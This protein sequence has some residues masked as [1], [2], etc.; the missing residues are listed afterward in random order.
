MRILV[1]MYYSR[2][3]YVGRISGRIFIVFHISPKASFM[4]S[5]FGA[6]QSRNFETGTL[7]AKFSQILE[8]FPKLGTIFLIVVA[9]AGPTALCTL[10]SVFAGYIG[11]SRHFSS[12]SSEWTRSTLV[13][14]LSVTTC[15]SAR[16]H[17][18]LRRR[19][20]N[21]Q[22]ARIPTDCVR[23]VSITMLRKASRQSE[24]SISHDP[25]TGWIYYSENG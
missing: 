5:Y 16:Q 14:C 23:R 21:F 10:L 25:T 20:E 3:V 11:V 17:R 8:V 18:T 15:R 19:G 6:N 12:Q 24:I 22:N 2:F 9:C 7:L 13:A 1:E 4:I